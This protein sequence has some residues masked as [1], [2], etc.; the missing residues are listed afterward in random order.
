[1]NRRPFILLV[2][3]DEQLREIESHSLKAAGYMVL[4]A[5]TFAEALDRIS[6][7]PSLMILDIH[8]PDVSGWEVARWLESVANWDYPDLVVLCSFW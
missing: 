3:D 1:M 8:L 7:K 6:I 4:K 2:E 5:G